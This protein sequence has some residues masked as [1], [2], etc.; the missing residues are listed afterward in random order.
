MEK[1]SSADGTTIAYERSGA[2]TPV[3]LVGGALCTRATTGPLAK[4]LEEDF[5]VVSYDRR[6]RGDSGDTSPYAV[7]R[8]VED[9]GALITAL[10]GVAAV[11]GHSSGA[12][13]VVQAAASGL[14]I[15]KVVLHEPPYGADDAESQRQSDEAGETVLRLLAE[16][17]RTAAVEAFLAIAGMPEDAAADW[18]AEPG[19]DDLAPTIAYDFAVM[20]NASQGGTV[21]RE[22]I[23][24]VT[25]PALAICGSVS[26]EFLID[27][28]RV[29]AKSLPGGQYVELD[30]HHHVVPPEVLA[31]V[32]ID[33]LKS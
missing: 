28:A 30:G 27:S 9:L 21:P 31:P 14:P 25:Q 33:F 17:R 8:E 22:L 11:Y 7:A 26:H 16:G 18:A 5:T 1:V 3:I 4:A 19:M 12:A 2:G 20:G 24:K 23:G 15:S 29:V 6:G 13:L 10:G 32:L